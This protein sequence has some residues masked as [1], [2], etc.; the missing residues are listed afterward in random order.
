MAAGVP[1]GVG[2]PVFHK[3]KADLARALLSLP[4]VLAFEY[5]A[6]FAVATMLVLLI[7]SFCIGPPQYETIEASARWFPP[8]WFVGLCQTLQGD[9]DPLMRTL[10]ERNNGRSKAVYADELKRAR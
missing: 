3:L 5:G 6:G 10:A 7:L 9:P 8:L 2:E 1:G 4:A